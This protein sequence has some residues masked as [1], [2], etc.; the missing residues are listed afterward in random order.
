MAGACR[1]FFEF[2]AFFFFSFFVRPSLLLSY[3]HGIREGAAFFCDMMVSGVGGLLTSNEEEMKNKKV[4]LDRQEWESAQDVAEFVLAYNLVEDFMWD[5]VMRADGGQFWET[6]QS[7]LENWKL[8]S[9]AS[10]ATRCGKPFLECWSKQAIEVEFHSVGLVVPGVGREE[11]EKLKEESR[12]LEFQLFVAALSARYI[13]EPWPVVNSSK[14]FRMGLCSYMPFT[15]IKRLEEEIDVSVFP[16]SLPFR[17]RFKW[18]AN[19]CEKQLRFYEKAALRVNDS[20]S[21]TRVLYLGASK[22]DFV[23]INALGLEKKAVLKLEKKLENM[24]GWE[25]AGSGKYGR[26]S[27][28]VLISTG[29]ELHKSHVVTLEGLLEHNY[30]MIGTEATVVDFCDAL[31]EDGNKWED[32]FVQIKNCPGVTRLD[33]SEN[34]LEWDVDGQ[35]LQTLATMLTDTADDCLINLGSNNLYGAEF[36]AW[37]SDILKS[38]SSIRLDL[39]GTLMGMGWHDIGW[40]KISREL[41]PRIIFL[42]PD[43]SGS[44]WKEWFDHPEWVLKN[45]VNLMRLESFE[46][47]QR[48]CA[49]YG[50]VIKEAKVPASSED[51][52]GLRGD[53]G[54]TWEPV[55]SPNKQIPC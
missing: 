13:R 27:V 22:N 30:R 52:Y 26:P 33:L 54:A 41:L 29:G 38:N 50:V 1:A 8:K 15:P 3:P 21:L 24:P 17:D 46:E 4:H 20:G 25:S 45:P 37:I 7:A 44:E 40:K 6:H 31:G 39:T 32:V 19:H 42:R 9:P 18:F 55:I 53:F 11:I 51:S 5:G 16:I 34:V 49:S 35:E 36:A 47:Y 48:Q 14:E 10:R 23:N 28:V 43:Y 2:A 12:S